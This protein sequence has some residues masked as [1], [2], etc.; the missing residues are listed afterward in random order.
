MTD[1]SVADDRLRNVLVQEARWHCTAARDAAN[2]LNHSLNKSLVI[3]VFRNI[4]SFLYHAHAVWEI[5]D[6]TEYKSLRDTSIE[7]D[8]AFFENMLRP[9]EGYRDWYENSKSH[10]LIINSIGARA[11]FQGFV[12]SD[13][14]GLFDPSTSEFYY[15][16]KRA[17]LNA[18]AGWLKNVESRLPT[19]REHRQGR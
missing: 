7:S 9:A 5:L 2:D 14:F 8:V 4:A 12:D 1:S 6:H 3:G 11:A 17:K 18:V 15:G 16:G 13:I 19:R 10:N